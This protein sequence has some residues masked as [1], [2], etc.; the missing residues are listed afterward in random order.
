[1]ENMFDL[2]KFELNGRL[3][4]RQRKTRLGGSKP[5]KKFSKDTFGV[6]DVGQRVL[7]A[8]GFFNHRHQMV[9]DFCRG[10]KHGCYLPLPGV[11]FQDVGNTQKPFRICH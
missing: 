8:N 7:A 10:R 3:Q 9:G 5:L 11:A 4:F 2:G 1:M 6:G